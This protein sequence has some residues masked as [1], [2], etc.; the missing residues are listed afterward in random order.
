MSLLLSFT[1]NA[2]ASD[3]SVQKTIKTVLTSIRYEK[4]SLASRKIDFDKMA[5][6]AMGDHWKSVG[7]DDRQR[8]SQGIKTITEKLSFPKAR[9]LFKHLDA[10]LY[11]APRVKNNT[12]HLKT[13]IVVHRNYKKEEVVIDFVLF[14]RSDQW[15]IVD[16][17][18]LGESTLEGVYEDQIEPLIDEGG[19]PSVLQALNR[20]LKTLK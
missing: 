17:V 3:K 18:I 5:E 12:A 14:K 8:L 4:D 13:T 20:K 1:A 11:D 9:E 10:V 2:H 7:P 6:L 16:T 15:K 19:V